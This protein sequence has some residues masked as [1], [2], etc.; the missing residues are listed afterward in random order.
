M[1]YS[2]CCLRLIYTKINKSTWPALLTLRLTKGLFDGNG[3]CT[4]VIFQGRVYT[5]PSG[6]KTPTKPSNTARNSIITG[7]YS[8]YA[9]FLYFFQL[10]QVYVFN[11]FSTETH[12]NHEFWGVIRRFY[13]YYVYESQKISGQRFV[14][15]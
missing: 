13:W 14:L 4:R 6:N 9:F 1:F 10:S 3:S 5:S 2:L 11:P 12:F 15:F 7:K 8:L